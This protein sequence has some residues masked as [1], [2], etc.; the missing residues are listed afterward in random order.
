[1]SLRRRENIKKSKYLRIYIYLIKV[2]RIKHIAL[3]NSEYF[4]DFGYLNWTILFYILDCM[5]Y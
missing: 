5:S 2:L 1:M 3:V 4:N